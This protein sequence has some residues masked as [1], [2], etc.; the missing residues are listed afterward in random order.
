VQP[1]PGAGGKWQISINGGRMPVW[2]PN[3][4]ELFYR[5][6]DQTMAV[7]VTAGGAFAS[8]KPRMLFEGQYFT[9]PGATHY[10]VA[11]DGKRFLMMKNVTPEAPL[12]QMNLVEN[13]FEELKQRAK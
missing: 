9:P 1:F 5:S 2:A 7:E 8:G 11:P 4:R 3:G 12:T 10:D 6:G 13:W